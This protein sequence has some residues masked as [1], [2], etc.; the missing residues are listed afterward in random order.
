MT[1]QNVATASIK[2]AVTVGINV[3]SM[4]GREIGLLED[5]LDV[6]VGSN[7]FFAIGFEWGCTDLLMLDEPSKSF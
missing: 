4:S 2:V 7:V 5:F 3:P 6:C 1:C